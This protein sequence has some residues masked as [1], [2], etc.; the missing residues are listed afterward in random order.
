MF[1]AIA[2]ANSDIHNERMHCAFDGTDSTDNDNT[3]SGGFAGKG[4]VTIEEFKE[5]CS[6][7]EQIRCYP[8]L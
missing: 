8:Y 6:I 1:W 7:A 2:E 4:D 3:E 5:A